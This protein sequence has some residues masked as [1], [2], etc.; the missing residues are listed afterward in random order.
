MS[1]IDVIQTDGLTKC[2]GS[3]NAVQG[4][5]FRIRA[6]RITGFLGQN[7]AGIST[8]I[9]MLLGM[10]RQTCGTG[11]VLGEPINDPTAS[12]RMRRNVAYV[13]EDKQLYPYMSVEEMIRFTRSFYT[14]WHAEIE[15]RLVSRYQLP[16]RRKVKAL[17]KGM[18]T[19]LA[20][21]LALSRRPSLL[22]LD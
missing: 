3:F 18:R 8:T 13:A 12:R 11:T 10:T 14:D 20:L 7:G 16:L 15:K 2:Y 6:G 21:L 1:V 19:K 4:L 9:K 5:T 22:I 17:S